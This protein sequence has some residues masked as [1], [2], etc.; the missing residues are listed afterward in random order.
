MLTNFHT[1]LI[2]KIR[3][4]LQTTNVLDIQR[5]DKLMYYVLQYVL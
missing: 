2:S 3:E 1:I 5:K 4:E